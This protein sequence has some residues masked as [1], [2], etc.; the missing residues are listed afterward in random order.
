MPIGADSANGHPPAKGENRQINGFGGHRRCEP[1]PAFVRHCDRFLSRAAVGERE[2]EKAAS[3]E[4]SDGSAEVP[5]FEPE[6]QHA[7][8]A[9]P[10][11]WNVA[12]RMN[13]AEPTHSAAVSSAWRVDSSERFA[14]N[15]A[16]APVERQTDSAGGSV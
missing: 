4:Q 10:A 11:E 9:L 8:S 3:T 7:V 14:G 6:I 5:C 1:A 15:P 12:A 13:V 16:A 2:T